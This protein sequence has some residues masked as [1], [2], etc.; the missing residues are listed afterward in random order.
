MAIPKH[1]TNDAKTLPYKK[2]ESIS[3]VMI[4]ARIHKKRLF[5]MWLDYK[6]KIFAKNCDSV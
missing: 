5:S 1:F 6:G 3:F 2:L 4:F